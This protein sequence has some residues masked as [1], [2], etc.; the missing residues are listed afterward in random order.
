MRVPKDSDIEAQRARRVSRRDFLKTSAAALGMPAII[1]ASAL[2]L[3]GAT[4]PSER[5]NLGVIGFGPRASSLVPLFLQETDLQARAVSDCQADHREAAKALIDG[6]YGNK[7]CA[8]IPDFRELLAR[9]DIDAVYIA[10]GNR[11]HGLGSIYAMR[12]GKD[13]Y[14][15]KP[16]SLSIG[17]G[18]AVVDTAGRF[19]AIYQGGHQRRSIDSCRFVAD[20]VQRGMIGKVKR[21]ILRCWAGGTIKEIKPCPVPEGFD[22]DLW[23]GGTPWHPFSWERVKGWRYFW[24]T[25]G[26][27][28]MDMNCHWTDLLSFCLGR[29]DTSP[30]EYQPIASEFAPDVASETPVTCEVTARYADG[31]E[32]LLQSKGTFQERLFRIEGD[33]GWV[34]FWDDNGTVKAEPESIVRYR[35]ITTRSYTEAGGHIRDFLDGIRLRRPTIDNP[36]AAHRAT[37][38]MHIANLS[39]RLGRPLRWDPVK[40][41]FLNDPEADRMIGRALR[42][43]WTV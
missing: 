43:P 24:D 18:R 1:P 34:E 5:I 37:V 20:V 17:E 21:A 6:T 29:D 10:A 38:T 30:V 23:L 35:A 36:L 16:V 25:G 39:L 42:P 3:N 2:G 19:G 13:V 11:W 14:A 41:R 28:F 7:D 9:P 27:M 4:A 26:G 8:M 40:E 22:Y 33:E 31:V 15:E 12:A 32:V